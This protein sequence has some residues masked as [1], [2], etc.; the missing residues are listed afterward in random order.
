MK[1]KLST[2]LAILLL[3]TFNFQLSTVSACTNFLVGKNA[4]VDG[5]VMI[6]YA[7]DSYAQYGFLN[8]T[9][10][11]DHP[12][13]SMRAIVD[14]DSGKP[15]GEIPQ[16][17]HTYSVVGYSNEHQVAVMETTWGGREACWDT[18][19]I[20]YV[21]LI[22]IAL[23]RSRSAREAI[24]VMVNLVAEYG[25]ASE[26]ESFS[27]AD[28][29]EV[30]L[31]DITGK[32]GKEKGA[33]W[34]VTRIPDDCIS[35]HANQ[36]RT[37]QLPLKGS[38]YDKKKGYCVSKDGTVLWSKDVI[39]F[40]R[41]N[42]FYT[43]EDADF[44]YAAVYNPYEFSGLYVCEARVW[45]F[46]RKFSDDMD[47][48]FDYASGKTFL[49]SGGKETGE[50]MPLYF[51]PNH[52][53]SAQ[54]LKECMRDQYEDTPLDITQS[55]VAGPWHS[56]LRYG[57]LTFQLDSVPYWYERPIATQQ[58]G[59]SFVAQL[60][61]GKEGILWFGVDD[62]ATSLYVPVYCRVTDV[63]ECYREGNG[64]LYTYS[65]TSAWWTF[66]IVAN[67]VY[68]KYDR[69]IVDLNKVRSI[70]DDKFNSQVAV[71]DAQVAQMDDA[72]CRDFLTRY[73]IA[74]A[75]ESHQAWKELQIYLFTKYL[76]GVERKEENGTFK[77][78]QWGQ[79]D[80][81]NRLPYP[82]SYLRHMSSVV[83]HE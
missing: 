83:A 62:A 80:G 53:V 57:G 35:A 56:K 34:V 42:G 23:E 27:I 14:G 17:A 19:G 26:G 59:C 25:Y 45:S 12:Q 65:P 69:M 43:G 79:P 55:P 11:A 36:A 37:Q 9:P 30:W 64:D 67:W 73:S 38:K 66:N 24:D 1:H 22:Q 51:R 48:Y 29:S 50:P 13:G 74:Q 32:G 60:R 2:L 49:Q 7:M 78:N 46:F 76:D 44:S 20:D 5:S 31:M 18:V 16:V 15:L 33:V 39:S 28:T 4:S 82:E 41:K 40:A 72:A 10:A 47:R 70:W 3:S 54:E 63:P 58:T 75:E 81:P 71:V 68:T 8:F 61:G 6:T 52:K 77:R 21:S